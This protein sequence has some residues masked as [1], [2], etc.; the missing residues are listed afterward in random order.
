MS[1]FS[2]RISGQLLCVGSV[3]IPVASTACDLLWINIHKMLQQLERC[4]KE[5]VLYTCKVI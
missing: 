4:G 1:E 2:G 3:S 5:D